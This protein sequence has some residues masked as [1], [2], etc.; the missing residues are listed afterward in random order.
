MTNVPPKS[1]LE[2]SERAKA[3]TGLRVGG[4]VASIL[5][6]WDWAS[7][8]SMLAPLYNWIG[9]T[10][11]G[12]AARWFLKTVPAWVPFTIAALFWLAYCLYVLRTRTET[13]SLPGVL[14]PQRLSFSDLAKAGRTPS[15]VS[16]AHVI[17]TEMAAPPNFKTEV[18]NLVHAVRTCI[19]V[20][21]GTLDADSFVSPE[22]TNATSAQLIATRKRIEVFISGPFVRK[23]AQFPATV[24]RLAMLLEDLEKAA[25][26]LD[27]AIPPS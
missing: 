21:H 16:R 15:S 17:L 13:P 24:R 9:T 4:I 14:E 27:D 22:I 8:L 6:L 5:F 1:T 18:L 25:S 3:L 2:D 26:R 23:D 7:R 12:E 20:Y 19:R 11:V 10:P